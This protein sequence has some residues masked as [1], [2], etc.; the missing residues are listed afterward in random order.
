MLCISWLQSWHILRGVS[1]FSCM[2]A[3]PV[4]L[5]FL[6]PIP[7]GNATISEVFLGQ[8]RLSRFP[9]HL[10]EPWFSLSSRNCTL[11]Y[12]FCPSRQ[13]SRK[14]SLHSKMNWDGAGMRQAQLQHPLLMLTPGSVSTLD[15]DTR[16]SSNCWGGQWS[17]P[18][19]SMVNVDTETSLVRQW[20]T[21][22]PKP[23]LGGNHWRGHWSLPW[24]STVD[25]DIEASSGRQP[26]MC[27]PNPPLGIN[28]R[29]GH[30]SF[31]WVSTI[32][33]DAKAYIVRQ[34]LIWTQKPLMGVKC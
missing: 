28:Y 8:T 16:F 29:H 17:L 7:T 14:P 24:M 9:F 22:T 20:L 3:Q 13:T 1:H 21:W 18:W 15:I 23:P 2:C 19:A 26:L 5:R 12:R 25:V 6:G 30:Q 27:T 34:P 11:Q 33:V 10:L 32:K 31:P 4:E